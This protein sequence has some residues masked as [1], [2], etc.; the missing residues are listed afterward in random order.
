L[1]QSAA[2]A[3]LVHGIGATARQLRLNATKLKEWLD[4]LARDRASAEATGFVEL[5]WFQAAAVPECLVEAE[6]R[7]GT[8]LRIHLKGPATAQA[9]SLTRMLWKDEE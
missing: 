6:D 7:L 4:K 9:A 2:R 5:P 8:R 3:A 1:W